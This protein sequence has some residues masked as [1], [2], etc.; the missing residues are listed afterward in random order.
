MT[1]R[2]ALRPFREDDWKAVYA[3]VRDPEIK[4]NFR[5][6]QKDLTEDD[7]KKFVQNQIKN[8]GSESVSLVLYDKADPEQKYIGSVS[9]KNIDSQD[10]NAELAIVIGSADYRGKGYGQEALYLICEHG[11]NILNLHKVY[12]TC[13][14]HNEGAIKSYE[15]FG[16]THEG[17]RKEQIFQAGQFHDEVLMGILKDTFRTKYEAE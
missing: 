4:N 9:L 14:A 2:I 12:L 10:Q 1:T 13:V 17:L 7:M 11:F 8:T 15:K 5:F 6:T 3:W 16:F